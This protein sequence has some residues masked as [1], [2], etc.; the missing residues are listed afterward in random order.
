MDAG[1]AK[2]DS[3]LGVLGVARATADQ[4]HT[5]RALRDDLARWMLQREIRQWRPGELP[6]ELIDL[7]IGEGAVHVVSLGDRLVGSVTVVWEDPLVWGKRPEPAGY[8][9][10]LM[11][12]REFC[13]YGIGGSILQWAERSISETGHSVARLDCVKDNRPLRAYYE[14]AGYGFVEDKAFP[15]IDWGGESALYEKRLVPGAG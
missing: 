12:N 14:A 13:G 9:H 15:D 1:T 8:I 7:C 3:A 10:M 11:V 6:V 5:V 2:I 4:A